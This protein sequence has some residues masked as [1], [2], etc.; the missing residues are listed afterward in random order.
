[1]N[2][3]FFSV[4]GTTSE[5]RFKDVKFMISRIVLWPNRW[6]NAGRRS[7]MSA[8]RR[9]WVGGGFKGSKGMSSRELTSTL[10]WTVG[11]WRRGVK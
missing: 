2:L 6:V 4:S 8:R 7:W 10:I 1:M 11:G 3:L 5:D 9:E